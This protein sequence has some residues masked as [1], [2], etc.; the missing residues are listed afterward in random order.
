MISKI[1]ITK[2]VE[3][4]IYFHMGGSILRITVLPRVEVEVVY[5]CVPTAPSKSRIRGTRSM[6]TSVAVVYN[7]RRPHLVTSLDHLY[8]K[9]RDDLQLPNDCVIHSLP[10]TFLTR[11]GEAGADAFTMDRNALSN[12]SPT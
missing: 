2:S 12:A 8:K 11:F 5:N 3:A 1:P 9:L 10:H 7:Y 4:K 6:W